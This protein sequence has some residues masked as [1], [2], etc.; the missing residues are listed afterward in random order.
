MFLTLCIHPPGFGYTAI[1]KHFIQTV[2]ILKIV[3]LDDGKFISYLLMA[4]EAYFNPC[5]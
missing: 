4:D 5:Q 1:T 2:Y 3:I